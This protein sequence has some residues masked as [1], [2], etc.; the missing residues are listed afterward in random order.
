MAAQDQ[1]QFQA[2]ILQN[3]TESVIVTDLTG[4]IIYWNEGAHALFGY[5]ADEMLGKTP[6]LLYPDSNSGLLED[7]LAAIQGGH[8]Y[9]G[10]WRGRRKDGRLIWVD[11][12]TTLFCNSQGEAIGFIGVAKDITENKRAEEEQQK[13]IAFIENSVDFIGC[14]DLETNA[15]FVNEAGQQLV[16]L[17]GL[18]EVR[19]TH[20][21]D[22]FPPDERPFILNHVL[23]IMF[24]QGFWRGESRFQ[25]FETGE[26]IPM[27]WNVFVIKDL[28]TGHPIGLG[29][30]SQI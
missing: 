23:P 30:I 24:E 11:I 8:D 16:G 12:K 2:T 3:I 28:E 27:S 7:D 17:H 4:K 14:A 29:Y 25:H 13:L 5:G 10:K 6:G 15:L 9:S 19:K 22:Y 20:V 26:V 21:I 1:L 18:E